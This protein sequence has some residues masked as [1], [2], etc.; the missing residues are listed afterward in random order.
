MARHG[1][2]RARRSLRGGW[3]IAGGI[4]HPSASLPAALVSKDGGAS[5]AAMPRKTGLF[6]GQRTEAEPPGTGD[7]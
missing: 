2:Q 4:R 5:E 6:S 7:G 3:L 1:R